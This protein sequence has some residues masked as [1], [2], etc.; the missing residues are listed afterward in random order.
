[1]CNFALYFTSG[2]NTFSGN[3]T[4]GSTSTITSASGNQ[5][6]TGTINGAYNLSVTISGDW[7]QTGN[8]GGISKPTSLTVTG[9]T[10]TDIY[11]NGDIEVN[12]NIEFR[13]FDVWVE[14]GLI[15]SYVFCQSAKK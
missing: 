1:M 10:S 3:I 14:T 6:I 7:T 4:L 13:A 8:I 2:N 12:G 9:T 5:I 11:I 15:R